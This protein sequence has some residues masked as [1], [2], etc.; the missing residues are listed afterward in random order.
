MKKTA[1]IVTLFLVHTNYTFFFSKFK[2]PEKI[3]TFKHTL[4]PNSNF[5][6]NNTAGSI[7]IKS[8][9]K[10]EL[11]IEAVKKG[12][13]A[14]IKETSI[15][16]N[17]TAHGAQVI[18]VHNSPKNKCSVDY[19]ILVPE[20]TSI[21]CAHT[22]QGTITVSNCSQ[23]I[24]L[25]VDSGSI[26]CS[27]V[28][29]N[30]HAHTHKGSITI[31]TKHLAKDQT[32]VAFSK[33]GNIHFKLPKD[34]AANIYAQTPRGKITS[35]HSITLASRT[36]PINQKTISGLRKDIKGFICN[37][38]GATIKAHTASGNIILGHTT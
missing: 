30:I 32:I 22:K 28:T 11:M 14:D 7:S 1:F 8:W 23:P 33:R 2:K 13:E 27:N 37:K 24:K 3:E 20:S 34:S 17:Y 9:K 25:E 5:E 4:T 6:I 16:T 15:K 29:N 10:P 38:K 19:T 18:T 21:T 31:Q 26:V 36:M 12:S 35:Q